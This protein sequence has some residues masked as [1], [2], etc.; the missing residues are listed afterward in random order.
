MFT[1]KSLKALKPKT[2]PYRVSEG[3]SD[4]GF[5]VQISTAGTKT[6]FL[7]YREDGK[8][9]Y[10]SLGQFPSITIQEAREKAR[11]CRIKITRGINPKT[12]K[13]IGEALKGTV[14]QLVDN[15]IHYLKINGRRSWQEVER[16]LI[17]EAVTPLGDCQ[18][19]DIT[20][21][22][23]KAILYKVI[24]R[25]SETQAN[26]V[27]SYLHT[28]FQQGIYHDNNPNQ[29][30]TGLLFGI[31]SNPVANIPVNTHAEHV[32]DRVLTDEEITNLFTYTGTAI[33]L[34]NLN[35]LKLIFASGGQRSGE[36]TR[37]SL[38]EFD[39]DTNIWA[40]PPER[41]KNGKWH[42]L[43]ITPMM[44]AIINNQIEWGGVD[45][46]YLFPMV[47]DRTKPQGKDTLSHAVEKLCTREPALFAKF[48]PKDLRRTAKT[49]MGR[50]SVSKE[51]RDR[52]QNH[53]LSDVSSKHYDR[54]DY[55][56]EK[57]QG[58]VALEA[59]LIN[60]IG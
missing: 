5:G 39:F 32:G 33:S 55:L 29:L 3:D 26:R 23:I 59:L 31:S 34:Q 16:V 19:S 49:V 4:K 44:L 38:A 48:I 40:I 9:K 15:Y 36:I 21:E 60:L 20:S 10:I 8:V 37:A 30:A 12:D 57:R 18:A 51:I 27:R 17:A 14:K 7:Q 56:P 11:L 53:A 58:L 43:P 46:V 41:T 22:Q 42:L 45:P 54:Y 25:G 2:T 28:A 50:L 13:L 47:G 52:L 1:D 6:F 35:A 24:Q